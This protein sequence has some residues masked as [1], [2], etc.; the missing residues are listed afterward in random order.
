MTTVPLRPLLV[1]IAVTVAASDRAVVAQTPAPPAQTPAAPAGQPAASKAADQKAAPERPAYTYQPE[2]RR[3]PF[4]SLLARGSDPASAA[5]R[6]PGVPGLLI[7][8]VIVKGIVRDKSGFIAMI[9][10]TD[11]KTFI[12]HSGEKLMDG[13]VKSITADTVIF[14]Q[15]VND[16]L[17]LVK[18][19]EV[20]KAVRPLDEQRGVRE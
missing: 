20:R 10:G 14:S 4:I 16:P 11:T 3:D 8:E 9:Q 2:G 7:N 19:R 12:V 1:V 15:D 17:S 13:M 6:P 5:S 18:Q